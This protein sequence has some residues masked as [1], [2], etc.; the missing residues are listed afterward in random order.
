MSGVSY[1][2]LI[3][4]GSLLTTVAFFSLRS[5][6]MCPHLLLGISGTPFL[7]KIYTSIRCFSFQKY[8]KS[9]SRDKISGL[10]LAHIAN[11]IKGLLY[12]TLLLPSEMFNAYRSVQSLWS[13]LKY[14]SV[15][16]TFQYNVVRFYFVSGVK[17]G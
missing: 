4:N 5:F 10:W 7:F 8:C 11:V 13:T 6:R 1:N 9:H 16:S 15:L 17:L 2:S 3:V 12:V 14:L